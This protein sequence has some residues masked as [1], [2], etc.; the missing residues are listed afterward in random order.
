M[1]SVSDPVGRLQAGALSGL[2]SV[3]KFARLEANA[4]RYGETVTYSIDEMMND[5]KK[6]VWG[7]LFT[8]KTIDVYRR[9][10]QKTY[11]QSLITVLRPQP[12]SGMIINL[13]PGPE[14]TDIPSIV[15]AH[16]QLLQKEINAALPFTTDKLSKYHLQDLAARIAEALSV[17]K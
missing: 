3:S 14:T 15:R 1:P 8:H 7:E 2:L 12:V 10:L 4:A 9:D 16:L 17:K 5:L 6:G 13:G 11:V